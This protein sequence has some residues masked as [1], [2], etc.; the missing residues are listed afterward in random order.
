MKM[1]KP[2]LVGERF[3]RLVIIAPTASKHNRA[4]WVAQCDC[5][6]TCVATGKT[7]REGKKKSCG[8]IKREQSKELVKALHEANIKPEGHASCNQLY[9]TYRWQAKN[10]GRVFE[11]SASDFMHLTSGTCYYCGKLPDKVIHGSSCKTPYTYNGVDRKDNG[12]GYTIENCVPCC[13]A[14]N[15]MK[16]TLSVTD[17]VQA[18]Q[19]VVNHFNFK[20][21][22]EMSDFSQTTE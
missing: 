18:C 17:F 7:L 1:D 12:V 21:S 4:R 10:R 2:N 20:K 6:N 8:C 9:A 16:R 14:C 19:A 13:T 22:A 5:G 11:L 3:G 15:W